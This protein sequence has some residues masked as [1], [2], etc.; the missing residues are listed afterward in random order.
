MNVDRRLIALAKPHK[1]PFIASLVSGTLAAL[2]L[3][4]QAALLSRVIDGAFLGKQ[5]LA[6][7][8][9]L[10]WL[11]AL[12]SLLRMLFSWFA[13]YQSKKGAIL[14]KQELFGRLTE[15]TGSLGPQ[16]VRSLQSGSLS[17]TLT[18]G[19]EALDAYF[20]QYL[21]QL[22]FALA[23]P[24]IILAAVVAADPLSALILL[25]SAPLIPIFMVLIG[26]SAGNMTDRQWKTMSRMSGYFLDRLQGLTTLK[27]F[28]RSGEQRQ[29]IE[30]AG[31]SFRNATMR[32]L[33]IAFLSSLTLELTGTLG[34]AII[35]VGVGIRLL[36]DHI[37]FMP[38]LFVLLLTPDFYLPLR[39]LGTKFHAG[40]EGVSASKDIFALLDAAA[41]VP[42]AA[43]NELPEHMLH[44]H[45]ILF[46]NVSYTYPGAAVPAIAG[47]TC[48]FPPGKTTAITGPS[49]SGKSTLVGLL[50]RFME[51][52]KGSITIDGEAIT[53]IPAN[54]LLRHIAWV[55][56]HP[57]LFN[58]SIRENL[59]L[60]KD[61]ATDVELH[62]ALSHAGL[63]TLLQS[64]PEGLDTIIGEQGTRLSG[65]EAQRLALARAIL[66]NAPVLVLDEPTS[67]T[68][69]LLEQS[70]RTTMQNLMAGKTVIIIAH[71][72]ETIRSA[73]SII[74]LRDGSI[75]QWGA[76]N[77]L[78]AAGGYYST[79]RQ[80][81]PEASV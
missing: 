21:P 73:D 30:D 60:A 58:A 53:R 26:K 80:D 43:S 56:Q 36:S 41:D 38:T 46:D 70:L 19:I 33:K 77:E 44:E 5:T 78:M 3:V 63:D 76:H 6:D 9:P 29:G 8:S 74:V 16:F 1:V 40:K 17:A 20:S 11:F 75:A 24:L 28:A 15:G 50:L 47:I 27:L 42:S 69:P 22:W 4:G 55:P 64:M 23:V 39:Q 37:A 81:A 31:E 66:K 71:R 7:L 57:F 51:P 72:Q 68:D 45:A 48:S 13:H 14:V 54:A 52:E 32:V 62:N 12:A 34:T 25:L 61:T 49:G 59:Q 65:G 2:T 10:I 67:N 18:K 79:V 35:A